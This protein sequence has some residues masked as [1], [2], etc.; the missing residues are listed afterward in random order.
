M[1][2]KVLAITFIC[3]CIVHS[4]I[5]SPGQHAGRGEIVSYPGDA[6]FVR[7]FRSAM[8]SLRF[9]VPEACGRTALKR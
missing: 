8:A 5:Q 6:L 2:I 3:C 7:G 1:I 4:L 9:A